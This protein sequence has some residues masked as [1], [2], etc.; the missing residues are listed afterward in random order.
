V[1]FTLLSEGNSTC[2]VP[3]ASAASDTELTNAIP[4][5]PTIMADNVA[6]NSSIYLKIIRAVLFSS[7][8]SYM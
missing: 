3:R 7:I 1:K 8:T 4:N 6:K 5:P 2:L